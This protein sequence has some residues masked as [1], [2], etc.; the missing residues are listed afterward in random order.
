ME[1]SLPFKHEDERSFLNCIHPIIR[2]LIPFILV[3]PFL[4]LNNIYLIFTIII[5][6]LIISLFARIKLIRILSRIKTILPFVI[7]ITIFIPLYLGKSVVF[8][9]DLGIKINIYQEGL[10][11]G[12]LLFMRIIGAMFVFLT[13]FS[14]LTYSEFVETLT[15]LRVPSMLTGS[16]I[17]M[18]HYIPILASSNTKILTAQELRG[19]K[20]TTYRE[21]LKTHAYIMGKSI[22]MNMERSERLYESLKMRGFSGRITFAARKFKFL[23]VFILS[24]FIILDIIL[25]FIINL[26]TIYIGV[27]SLLF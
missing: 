20:I 6:T 16:L 10:L 7:I 13:F 17:I 2:F 4:I 26:E 24:I 1:S 15:K 8:Q 27:I 25:I 18:L 9:I 14:S 5:I 22:V 11:F 3:I 19:K 21:K 12:F 23:D